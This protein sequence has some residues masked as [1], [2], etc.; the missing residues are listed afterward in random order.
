[1]LK[2]KEK[3]LKKIYY[4]KSIIFLIKK[5]VETIADSADK[6]LKQEYFSFYFDVP[7]CVERV[8]SILSIQ[9]VQQAVGRTSNPPHI[10]EIGSGIGICC[11]IMKALTNAK[12]TGLEPAPESYRVL[13]DC[14]EELQRANLHLYYEALNCGGEKIP[15]GNNSIDFIYSFEV[16]EHVQ[17]PKKVLGE[18]YR[19]LKPGGCAYIAT[20]NY[21]SFWGG[22]YKCFWNPFIGVEGNKK[23]FIKKGLS[24]QFLSELNF[25]TKK[26]I[27]KWSKDIGFKRLD[28]NPKVGE[29]YTNYIIVPVFPTG[30]IINNKKKKNP[31]LYRGLSN[32][33][34]RFCL[35]KVD[36]E[37]KLYFILEK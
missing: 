35:S 21:D 4:S 18:I 22:H 31:W 37:Y 15:F 23:R 33:I 12:I 16:L 30:F 27:K 6:Q 29:N 8:K 7:A 3:I 20:S 10:L 34:I 26:Q 32:S 14:I 11:L 24:L 2:H 13:R 9:K 25:V 19:V 1:M 36:R 17:D 28:F 5:L